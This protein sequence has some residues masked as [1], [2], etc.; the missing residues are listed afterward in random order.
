MTCGKTETLDL[1]HK[2][3]CVINFTH[4]LTAFPNVETIHSYGGVLTKNWFA[5]IQQFK[6]HPLK[7][8]RFVVSAHRFE[9]F[10]VNA[11]VKFL[12]SRPHRVDILFYV[13]DDQ[14]KVEAY[15]SELEQI[16]DQH[17]TR[18]DAP[19]QVMTKY[20]RFMLRIYEQNVSWLLYPENDVLTHEK[21]HRLFPL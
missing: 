14:R 15:A 7:L 6:K 16:L 11:F 20:T 18:S 1:Q 13:Y 9:P 4:L 2:G 21:K 17:L 8:V 10:D 5:D 3:G 19:L 12:K